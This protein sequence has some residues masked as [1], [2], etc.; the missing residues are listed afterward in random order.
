MII[1]FLSFIS[2][3]SIIMYIQNPSIHL[4]EQIKRAFGDSNI[5]EEI[6]QKYEMVTEKIIRSI[7]IELDKR[8]IGQKAVKEQILKAIF[9]S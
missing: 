4:Q 7:N 2:T 6:H 5:I 1:N 8:V 9:Q 3:L